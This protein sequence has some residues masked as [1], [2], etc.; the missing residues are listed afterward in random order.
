MGEE[1]RT[2]DRGL[3]TQHPSETPGP[4]LSLPPPPDLDPSGMAGWG[5]GGRQGL[6][7]Y[8]PKPQHQITTTL[9]DLTHNRTP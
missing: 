6:I 2:E 1:G 9:H 7:E 5:W 3:P 8:H 4:T